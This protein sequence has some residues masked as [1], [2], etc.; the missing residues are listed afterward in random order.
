MEKRLP[1]F[2]RAPA[3]V[4]I[5]ILPWARTHMT[6]RVKPDIFR[7]NDKTEPGVAADLD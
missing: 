3:V 7:G 2:P 5:P 1:L 6:K 4:E